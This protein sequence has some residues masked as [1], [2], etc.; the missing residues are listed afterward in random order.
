[1]TKSTDKGKMCHDYSTSGSDDVLHMGPSIPDDNLH[2]IDEAE[3]SRLM[4]GRILLLPPGESLPDLPLD[5]AIL[6]R[7]QGPFGNAVGPDA[8]EDGPGRDPNAA[9][10]GIGLLVGRRVVSYPNPGVYIDTEVSGEGVVG[11]DEAAL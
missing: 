11:V 3:V 9:A 7:P 5:E 1:M 4:M 10:F 6:P 2:L 8:P